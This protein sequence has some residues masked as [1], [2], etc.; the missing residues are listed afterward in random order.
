MSKSNCDTAEF[1]DASHKAATNDATLALVRA[2]EPRM[3]TWIRKRVRSAD[4]AERMLRDAVADLCVVLDPE[5]EPAVAWACAQGILRRA[6]AAEARE[7][8]RDGRRVAADADVCAVRLAGNI[9][10]DDRMA[11]W[12]WE[13]HLLG[14]LSTR[15]RAALELHVM[16]GMSDEEIAVIVDAS[17]K[18][19]KVLRSRAKAKLRA[20]IQRRRVPPPPVELGEWTRRDR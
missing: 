2:M 9:T 17:P 15:Q 18:S 5:T 4:A 16:D 19:I 13:E 14:R 3:A 10:S 8:R 1:A 11:L 12:A 6:R 7:R 20:L